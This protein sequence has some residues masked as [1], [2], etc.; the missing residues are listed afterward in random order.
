MKKEYVKPE[1]EIIEMSNETPLLAG[2]GD[3]GLPGGKD[4]SWCEDHPNASFCR[5]IDD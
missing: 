2:S 4:F 5:N 3:S 1:M